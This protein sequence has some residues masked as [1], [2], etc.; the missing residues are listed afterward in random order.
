MTIK[1][2]LTII[3]SVIFLL[4]SLAWAGHH[5]RG[6]GGMTPSWDMSV[7]DSNQDKAL[8]FEEYSERQTKRLRAGF[9]MIDGNNDGVIS[10]DEW[11][12]FLQVHGVDVE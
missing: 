11:K 9:D 4:S 12:T 2:H 7:M 8:T 6:H 3:V 5:Y 10:E 1:H